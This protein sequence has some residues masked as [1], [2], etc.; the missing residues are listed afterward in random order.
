MKTILNKKPIIGV[1][2]NLL[3]IE[4][5]PFTGHDRIYVNRSYIQSIVKAGGIPLLL[6]VITDLDS[7][8]AQLSLVDGLILSG[9]QDVDPA[10]YNENPH[11]LLGEISAERDDFELNLLRIAHEQKKPIFGICRGLQLMNVAF[12]GTLYQDISQRA[13]KKSIDHNM[14]MSA[15]SLH[16]VDLEP[17]SLLHAIFGKDTIEI[18]SFHHQAVKDLA[19]G[20][21]V[22]ARAKDGLIEG[23][24]KADSS[25]T[26]GVQWHPEVMLESH[27]EMQKL[28]EAFV[29]AANH[30]NQANQ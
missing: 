1:S 21:K 29:T 24:V 12:G 22:I 2:S 26:L 17:A 4:Q 7:I 27:P 15:I 19:P 11:P 20:F 18:N 28:F 8:R 10:H 6:P 16:Q 5:G 3:P 9:G 23:I 13:E 30:F 25:W 14:G